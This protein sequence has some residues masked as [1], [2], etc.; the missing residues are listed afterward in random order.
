MLVGSHGSEFDQDF[1]RSLTR[2]QVELRQQVLDEM[3][4]IAARDPLFRIEPKP[5]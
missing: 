1:V 5:A 4:R 2:Q 3:H